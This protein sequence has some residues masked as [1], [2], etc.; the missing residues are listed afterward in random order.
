MIFLLGLRAAICRSG[1]SP[2][3]FGRGGNPARKKMKLPMTLSRVPNRRQRTLRRD[4][5]ERFHFRP[6]AISIGS[7][8]K[9]QLEYFGN[10]WEQNSSFRVTVLD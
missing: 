3:D 4:L 6:A 8:L 7:L 10:S 9:N 1:H 5:V 2:N